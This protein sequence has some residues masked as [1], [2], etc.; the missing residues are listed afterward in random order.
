LN[1]GA[2]EYMEDGEGVVA[3]E[4]DPESEKRELAGKGGLVYVTDESEGIRR[5]RRGRGFSYF[6]GDGRRVV[7]KEILERI[8]ELAI[9]PAWTDVWIGPDPAGHIQATGRDAK[10]R[11]QYVYHPRWNEI[12]AGIKF[13]RLISFGRALPRIRNRIDSD[14]RKRNLSR[15]KVTSLV[16]ALLDTAKIRVGN[17]EYARENRS[18]GLTTLRNR[19]VDV[20][21]STV[22]LEFRGK[23]GKVRSVDI[24]NRR[25]ARQVKRCQELPGQ[26]LF[27]YLDEDGNRR[28]IRSEDV[29]EYLGEISSENFTAKDF[30]TWWGTVLMAEELYALRESGGKPNPKK[31]IVAAVRAVAEE[32]GNTRSVCKKYYIH[33]AVIEAFETGRLFDAFERASEPK[34][35]EPGDSDQLGIAERAV[36][37]LLEQ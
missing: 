15:R 32:L 35:G 1:M 16:V 7:E 24:E 10:G 12:R 11:K 28:P 29:N 8:K 2:D 34:D 36:L 20:F 9:P 21:G 22:H 31:H 30:R 25:L 19:H 6:E 4:I 13:D 37:E 3:G 18:Y 14:L 17:P 33:P 27:Q 23:S 5:K 26:E